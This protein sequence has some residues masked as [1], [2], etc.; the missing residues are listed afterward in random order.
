M[1]KITNN[2]QLKKGTIL[3]AEFSSLTSFGQAHTKVEIDGTEYNLVCTDLYPGDIANV[4]LTKIKKNFLEAEPEE[5]LEYSDLRVETKNNYFGISNATPLEALSYEKQLELKQ[6][7]VTRILGNL[8]L[9][10]NVEVAPIQ[11]M[12]NPWYYRN[13]VE[14]SFG[15]DADFNPVLGFH[16]KNRRFD[17]VDVTSCHLFNQNAGQFLDVARKIFLS[18]FAPYQ[19][20]CNK[21]ELRTLTFKQT[22]NHD[23]L[24]IILEISKTDQ[25]DAIVESL[26]EFAN[27]IQSFYQNPVSVY[28]QVTDVLKGRRTLKTI[29]HI[30]GSEF[31]SETL[32]INSNEYKFDIF[33]DSF[34][35]PNPKQ[36]TK[37]FEIVQD[38]TSK[39][40]SKVIYDLFCGTGTLGIVS[41]SKDA[42]IFGMDI[43]ES[44]IELARHN[45][46]QNN[47]SEALYVADDIFKHL[48]DYPWPNP[49]LILID[50]PRKGLE[51]KTIELIENSTADILVYVS[52]NLK[53]FAQDARALED[54]GFKLQK[55]TPVDQFPHT[56]HLEIVSVFTRDR[57]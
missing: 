34:F 29:T 17:I 20:S 51:P 56:K 27:Q 24:M 12:Q 31:I 57:G 40:N 55:L 9:L 3:K 45:A 48:Q 50:P 11:A 43:V 6:N 5:I 54:N 23:Q 19:F 42:K 49:D 8:N 47:I 10:T 30:Q 18:K 26:K 53:T 4:K 28:L 32:L 22:Q 25:Q 41:A 39:Y 33:P 14:Y 44:S 1:S 7:E 37:I 15:F 36:A 13:K 38:I 35:Q 21:G 52:C 46:E 16:V 2:M